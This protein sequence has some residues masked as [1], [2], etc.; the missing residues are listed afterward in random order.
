MLLFSR[1]NSSFYSRFKKF[2]EEFYVFVHECRYEAQ[3]F[4]TTFNPLRAVYAFEHTI[5]KK[6]VSKKVDNNASSPVPVQDVQHATSNPCNDKSLSWQIV[7]K[8]GIVHKSRAWQQLSI[9]H[10]QPNGILLSPDEQ[11]LYV[12]D[13][14]DST[15]IKLPED[16]TPIDHKLKRASSVCNAM[17]LFNRFGIIVIQYLLLTSI[18]TFNE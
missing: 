17:T 16:S 7:G 5:Q 14:W 8:K 1:L 15:W 3:E 6:N 11:T 2:G 9:L 4:R 10:E 12:S 18:D 13:V